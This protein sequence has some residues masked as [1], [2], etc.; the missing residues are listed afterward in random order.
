MMYNTSSFHSHFQNGHPQAM[1][2]EMAV[3]TATRT[4]PCTPG[5]CL[6]QHFLYVFKISVGTQTITPSVDEKHQENPQDCIQGCLGVLRALPPKHLIYL[7]KQQ[8]LSRPALWNAKISLYF[9]FFGFNSVTFQRDPRLRKRK[10]MC[11]NH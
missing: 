5:V 7:P 9:W 10:T 11:Q 1:A 2:N 8:S 3:G 6:I 4:S